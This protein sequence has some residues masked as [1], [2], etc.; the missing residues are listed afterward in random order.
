[1]KKNDETRRYTKPTILSGKVFEQA[2][3]A[4]SHQPIQ[5]AMVG[6]VLLKASGNINCGFTA[7]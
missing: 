1:M 6:A 4:C 2:A 3:L 5:G 7:S